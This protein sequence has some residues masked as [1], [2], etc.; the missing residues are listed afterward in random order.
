MTGPAGKGGEDVGQVEMEVPGRA[1][2]LL[3]RALAGL[4]RPFKPA[5]AAQPPAADLDETMR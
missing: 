1:Q 3:S 5:T 4:T 2:M